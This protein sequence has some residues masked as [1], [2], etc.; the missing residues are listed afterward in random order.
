MGI[1]PI[2]VTLKIMCLLLSSSFK[3]FSL[4]QF[5]AVDKDMSKCVFVFVLLGFTKL[6][7]FVC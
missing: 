4:P 6:L 3:I 1:S 2:V 7:E 5:S